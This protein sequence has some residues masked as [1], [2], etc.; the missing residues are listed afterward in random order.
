MTKGRD[1]LAETLSDVLELVRARRQTG[2]L[3]IERLHEGRYEEGEVYVQ[4]GQ[5]VYAHT[6]QLSGQEALAR[7]LKWRQIYFAFLSDAGHPTANISSSAGVNGVSAS[8]SSVSTLT[9][10]R[11]SAVNGS[12]PSRSGGP[13]NVPLP[14]SNTP[15][16]EMST[17]G[18]EWLTPR[19]VGG[20]H[21]VMA[22]PLTRPQRSVYLLIDGRRT[23]ADLSRC[24]RKSM[25]EIERLLSE[26][27]ERGL[28]A[29]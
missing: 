18:L 1:N 4:G 12:T 3:S 21:D 28:I 8:P 10:P 16:T 7:L 19:K 23:V 29:I 14:R 9:P 11:F 26:L 17:P 20:E 13:E 5:A 25:Q 24:T 22:L 15:R 27:Q 6:G 2:L